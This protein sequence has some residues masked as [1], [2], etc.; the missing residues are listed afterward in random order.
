MNHEQILRWLKEKDGLTLQELWQRADLIRHHFVGDEVHLRGLLEISNHCVRQCGYCGL[1]AGNKKIERY[2]MSEPEIMSC[3]NEA[4][5]RGYGTVV[6]QAGE[7]YGIETGMLSTVI[8][9]IKETTPLAVTLSLGERPLDDLE[10]WHWAGA[11]RYLLRFETSDYSLYNLIHPAERRGQVYTFTRPSPFEIKRGK[12][13]EKGAGVEQ[14][15]SVV[16]CVDPTPRMMLLCALR[17]IGYEIGGGVMVGIPGQSFESLAHDIEIFREFDLDMI[18]IGPYIAHPDTP[19]GR[20]EWKKEIGYDEQVPN[21]QEMTCKVIALA[22]IVC[23]EAN[24]PATTALAT[25]NSESGYEA[26][27]QRG[28]NVVMPELT[29]LHYRSKY[30]IYPARKSIEEPPPPGFSGLRER[31]KKIGRPPG[32]GPGG[33]RHII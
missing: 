22:R 27:L 2:R 15:E 16:K 33:R 24:I 26:G 14:A 5:R 29:P 23:P 6:I 25:I 20:G 32:I 13:H 7:D 4:V 9:R 3:V 12:S 28:A 30:E 10:E 21:T 1:R 8:H 11:D 17:E 19:L 31:L 18:G